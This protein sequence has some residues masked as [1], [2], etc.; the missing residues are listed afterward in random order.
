MKILK[1]FLVVG[2]CMPIGANGQCPQF[3]TYGDNTAPNVLEIMHDGRRTKF[4]FNEAV[5]VAHSTEEYNIHVP[6]F[7]DENGQLLLGFGAFSFTPGFFHRKGTVAYF[8]GYEN[9]PGGCV[10]LPATM[11]GTRG[12]ANISGPLPTLS[13]RISSTWSLNFEI[14]DTVN[15]GSFIKAIFTNL[16]VI[17]PGKGQ[18]APEGSQVFIGR[19]PLPAKSF[20]LDYFANRK[21]VN[22]YL[23][24]EE[25][26]IAGTF[27]GFDQKEG[28]YHGRLHDEEQTPILAHVLYA[29]ENI[30]SINI[31]SIPAAE[32]EKR[33]KIFPEYQPHPEDLKAVLQRAARIGPVQPVKRPDP[34]PVF[35]NSKGGMIQPQA[36]SADI[37][38]TENKPTPLCL[39]YKP[40]PSSKV[41]YQ[42]KL[43][44]EGYQINMAVMF[45]LEPGSKDEL[46]VLLDDF[47]DLERKVSSPADFSHKAGSLLERFKIDHNI[48][49]VMPKGAIQNTFQEAI[50]KNYA[51]HVISAASEEHRR[52]RIKEMD[53]GQYQ[54]KADQN[55]RPLYRKQVLEVATIEV[56][57]EEGT[58]RVLVSQKGL[59][60]VE[61]RFNL[62]SQVFDGLQFWAVVEGAAE[63]TKINFFDIKTQYI[64]GALTLR[65]FIAEILVSGKEKKTLKWTH[66]A[67]MPV[68]VQVLTGSHYTYDKNPEIKIS[69]SGQS[70]PIKLCDD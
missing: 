3:M 68:P 38:L 56:F 27:S 49:G 40:G 65:P 4:Y 47:S 13:G 55:G 24:S 11:P 10:E 28:W 42:N 60:P 20:A 62:E 35:F 44:R 61:A 37:L 53:P 69:G 70:W 67:L 63:N 66:Q 34:S 12:Q 58:A 43:T 5:A 30:R 23:A 6:Y 46:L 36:G 51:A 31:L 1:M 25:K 16:E 50:L 41:E 17:S 8:A 18:N 15:K 26:A 9:T 14:A 22:F 29:G 64:N 39:T 7:Y 59:E 54:L 45:D 52:R 32:I 21:A 2:A 48:E 57:Y 33:R 19:K